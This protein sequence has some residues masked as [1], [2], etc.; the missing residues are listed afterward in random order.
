MDEYQ[1]QKQIS[2]LNCLFKTRK[3]NTPVCISSYPI[4]TQRWQPFAASSRKMPW[5][6]LICNLSCWFFFLFLFIYRSHSANKIPGRIRER[7]KEDST[8]PQSFEETVDSTKTATLCSSSPHTKPDAQN[9]QNIHFGEEWT[10][11]CRGFVGCCCSMEF[12]FFI[13]EETVG[14][15]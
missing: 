10:M 6:H 12:L 1:K 14:L 2:A 11:L 9:H 15:K 3:L 4:Y 5:T 8:N 7:G 13:A